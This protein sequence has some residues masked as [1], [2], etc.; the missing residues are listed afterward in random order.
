MAD[1]VNPDKGRADVRDWINEGHVVDNYRGGEG[2]DRAAWLNKALHERLGNKGP[3]GKY[4]KDDGSLTREGK[5]AV[6][7]FQDQEHIKSDGIIGRQTLGHLLHPNSERQGLPTLH[8]ED[9]FVNSEYDHHPLKLDGG[10]YKGEPAKSLKASL[11]KIADDIVYNS[12]SGDKAKAL[13]LKA[14]L[15]GDGLKQNAVRAFYDLAG[16]R[17]PG[18]LDRLGPK[19]TQ[20]VLHELARG[21]T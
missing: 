15:Q 13:A 1:P 2:G 10:E 6:K 17:A 21:E 4:F 14:A 3:S 18:N 7:A 11:N 9:A 12:K 20:L 16:V 8:P 5:A 19:F